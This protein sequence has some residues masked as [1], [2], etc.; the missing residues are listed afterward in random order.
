LVVVEPFDVVVVVVPVPFWDG[1]G[2][3]AVA[4]AVVVAT[5]MV[6]TTGAELLSGVFLQGTIV[7]TSAVVSPVASTSQV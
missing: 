1:G 4:G 7:R 6:V 3:V 2:V 5:V